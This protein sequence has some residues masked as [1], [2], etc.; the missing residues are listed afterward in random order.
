MAF[1]ALQKKVSDLLTGTILEIPRNQR[2]YV[3]KEE[4]W[5]DLLNDLTAVQRKYLRHDLN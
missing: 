3:W 2:R 4:H 1:K 5:R